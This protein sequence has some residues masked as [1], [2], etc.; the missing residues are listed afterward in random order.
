MQSNTTAIKR[1]NI[2]TIQ[3]PESVHHTNGMVGSWTDWELSEKG[4]RLA[5]NISSHL[6]QTIHHENFVIY[7][8]TLKRGVQTA[9][10]VGK[11][12]GLF[13]KLTAS[14]KERGLGAAIGKSVQWLKDNI[15]QEELTVYDKCFANAESRYDVWK[16]LL[17]FYEEIITNE[18]E[19]IIIVSHGDTLSIFNAMWLGLD[20][21]L[22]NKIDLYGTSGGVSFL[23]QDNR[24]KRII[25]RLSDTSFMYPIANP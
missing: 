11:K 9:E 10:I 18:E 12:L 7:S 17:P 2:I 13:P 16:R 25:K 19:N 23:Y 24:G 5:E 8:S 22:L 4:K 1:K 21:E 14:L 20:I 3:H 6:K 15:E